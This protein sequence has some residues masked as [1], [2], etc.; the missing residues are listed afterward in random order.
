[1][2][3]DPTFK[4]SQDYE[5]VRPLKKR[6]Y[7]ILIEE[8]EHLK[9]KINSICDN[10]NLFH[11]AGSVLLGISG[12]ALVAALTLNLPALPNG[13]TPM[14]IVLSWLIVVSALVCGCLALFFG[15]HQRK[16]QNSTAEDVVEHMELIEKRYEQKKS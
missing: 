4:M 16:V 2:S 5:L 1:M 10:A 11:T 8:W 13:E 7:P 3:D 6:A 15:H 14:P 12:S 9:G